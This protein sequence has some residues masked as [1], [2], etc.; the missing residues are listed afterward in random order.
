MRRNSPSGAIDHFSPLVSKAPCRLRVSFCDFRVV[1]T[2]TEGRRTVSDGNVLRAWLKV[3]GFEAT[4][5]SVVKLTIVS[6]IYGIQSIGFSVVVEG[7]P[8]VLCHCMPK[9]VDACLG[10]PLSNVYAC[11]T[12]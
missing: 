8:I 9:R 6:R 10:L 7:K 11:Y 5:V 3:F 12:T 4:M 2:L 1:V